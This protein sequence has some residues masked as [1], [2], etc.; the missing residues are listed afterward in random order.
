[1]DLQKVKIIKLKIKNK[2]GN[3]LKIINKKHKY[4]KN[5]G[6]IYFSKIKKNKIKG[7]NL[8]K[9]FYCHITICYGDVFEI[10]RSKIKN[11]KYPTII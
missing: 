8:H 3:I 4:F 11:K 1:M 9:R 10:E 2:K 7:W 5:F 6:E